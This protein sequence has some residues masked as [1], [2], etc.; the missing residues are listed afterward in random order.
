MLMPDDAGELILDVFQFKIHWSE[1][2]CTDQRLRHC[3]ENAP[4]YTILIIVVWIVQCPAFLA[5]VDVA[6]E[7]EGYDWIL[8]LLCFPTA[9]IIT[10]S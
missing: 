9:H 7:W 6:N 5:G 4:S 1:A 3:L 2:H 10:F 8:S